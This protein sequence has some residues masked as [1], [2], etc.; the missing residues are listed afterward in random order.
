MKTIQITR[1][2]LKS[3]KFTPMHLVIPTGRSGDYRISRKVITNTDIRR[4]NILSMVSDFYPPKKG[5][6]TILS[7]K[8]RKSWVNEDC[9]MSDAEYEKVTNNYIM[10]I[11]GGTILIAGLGLGMVIL[12]LLKRS[13]VRKIIV[14]EKEQDVIN[15]VYKHIKKFD[16][17]N[18]LELIH[19]DIEN[20]EFDKKI[21]FDV[22]YFDIWDNVCGDNYAQMKLLRK[23]FKKNRA[24][25]ST[26]E[27]WEEDRTKRYDR[28]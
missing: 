24:R 15:L 18:K 4:A 25:P 23:K 5:I 10:Q 21:K 6:I 20:V 8:S 7:R 26:V 1:A 16:T 9:I 22:I 27:S 13:R 11:A 12:P 3:D 28:E 19:D 2:K 17:S 14:V